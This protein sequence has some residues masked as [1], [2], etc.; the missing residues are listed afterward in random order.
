MVIQMSVFL[1]ISHFH[2]VASSYHTNITEPIHQSNFY[3]DCLIARSFWLERTIGTFN[4]NM[5]IPKKKKN[6]NNNSKH[7][8]TTGRQEIFETFSFKQAE[9]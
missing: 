2:Q 6:Q 5:N 4:I 1:V 3:Q 7:V 9:E 8:I